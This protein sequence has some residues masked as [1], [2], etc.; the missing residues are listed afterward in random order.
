[1]LVTRQTFVWHPSQQ[2][3]THQGSDPLNLLE[4]FNS[5]NYHR[6]HSPYKVV[7]MWYYDQIPVSGVNFILP[8]P[9]FH[10]FLVF[11][12]QLLFS[13]DI[14]QPLFSKYLVRKYSVSVQNSGS[15]FSEWG[16]KKPL[17]KWCRYRCAVNCFY[18]KVLN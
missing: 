8:V 17:G 11:C 12:S 2:T 10:V 1:M 9:F 13:I 15:L 3:C 14:K 5:L 16:L 4:H 18:C 7:G 6:V